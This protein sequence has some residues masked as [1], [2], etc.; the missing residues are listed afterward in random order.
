MTTISA[1]SPQASAAIILFLRVG[2]LSVGVAGHS[3]SD[4]APLRS[5]ELV[6]VRKDSSPAVLGLGDIILLEEGQTTLSRVLEKEQRI[7]RGLI[8]ILKLYLTQIFYLLILIVA[9]PLL[10]S[11]FPYSSQQAGLINLITLTIPALALTLWASIGKLPRAKL[12]SLLR[13]FV[14]PAALSMALLGFLV[15]ARVLQNGGSINY[16]QNVLV[17]ALIAMGLLLVTTI[18]PPLYIHFTTLPQMGD[19]RPSIMVIIS[20]IVFITIVR[21][22]FFREMFGIFPL[23]NREDLVLVL[24][25]ALIAS[26]E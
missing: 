16:A 26:G 4:V 19:G 10:L 9:I 5:A 24:G 6:I 13:N 14:T 20:M 1:L 22:P 15:Y 25:S 7:V 8:D 18:K 3:L 17:F 23:Q 12:S 2:T 11:G 21:I